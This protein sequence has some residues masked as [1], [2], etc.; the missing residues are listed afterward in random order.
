MT[1][2]SS[3]SVPAWGRRAR[4]I[5][6]LATA[7]AGLAL[8][9]RLLLRVSDFLFDTALSDS[10]LHWATIVVFVIALATLGIGR[11]IWWI[12]TQGKAGP[13]DRITP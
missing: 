9:A 12:S 4:E 3:K 5:S 11:L 6:D 7:V 8:A 10:W 1:T 2:P 13:T